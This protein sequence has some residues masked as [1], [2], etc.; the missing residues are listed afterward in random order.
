MKFAQLALFFA[1]AAQA[2]KL[3]SNSQQTALEQVADPCEEALEVS[4]EELEIQLDY[5]SRTF[6]RKFYDNAMK[7]HE[8]LVKQ[9]QN[10]KLSV[11]SWELYDQSFA[12]PR[13]RRYDLVQQQM[14]LLQHFEDNLNQNFTNLQ[15]LANFIR[16]GKQAESTLNEKYHDG[17]FSDPAGFDPQDEHK[18]TWATVKL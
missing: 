7:I 3:T 1:G 14:D 5:F 13:V 12:F 2:L 8:E 4:K 6:D 18:T 15:H 11:H 16:V 17:E 9:G 10:P